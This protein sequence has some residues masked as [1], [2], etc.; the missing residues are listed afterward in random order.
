MWDWS[1]Q[2]NGYNISSLFKEVQIREGFQ[3]III[4]LPSS[5]LLIDEIQII[6]SSLKNSNKITPNLK[7]LQ[8]IYKVTKKYTFTNCKLSFKCYKLYHLS[9]ENIFSDRYTKFNN[10]KNK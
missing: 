7:S 4:P 9:N 3:K 2:D 1:I 8:E 6:S 5:P 10:N